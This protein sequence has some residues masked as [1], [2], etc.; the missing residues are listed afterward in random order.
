MGPPQTITL[1]SSNN[2]LA[3]LAEAINSSGA[4]V[5]ASVL[6]DRVFAPEPGLGHLGGGRQISILSNSISTG[7]DASLSYTGSTGTGDPGR[8]WNADDGGERERRAER[9]AL[10]DGGQRD[11][12][13]NC[14][15]RRPSAGA[16]ANTF[17]TGSG[18][19]TLAGLA[20]AIT[21]NAS[22]LGIT[23]NVVTNNDGSSSL[24]LTSSTLGTAG[25]L[26]VASTSGR[27]PYRAGLQHS[28]DRQ[29]RRA[30]DRWRGA[31]QLLEYGGESDSRA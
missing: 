16:A 15:W 8:K 13:K 1:N 18:V 11:G 25:N 19:N 24:S 27:H 12:R 21:A 5:T 6:T 17:Y 20:A 3:G 29:G 26:T 22:A 31:D 2:T 10:G 4:G 7:T 9:H 30:V 28:S 23:A 14:D